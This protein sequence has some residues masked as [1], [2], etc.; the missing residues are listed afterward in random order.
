MQGKFLFLYASYGPLSIIYI[1]IYI[2][3]RTI[4]ILKLFLL[5]SILDRF[6]R[7]VLKLMYTRDLHDVKPRDFD[8]LRDQCHERPRF[9]DCR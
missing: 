5:H 8:K 1:Y 7:L 3:V 6:D 9:S 4:S 2:S